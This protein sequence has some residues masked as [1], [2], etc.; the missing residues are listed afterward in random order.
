VALLWR[1]VSARLEI[2]RAARTLLA[3]GDGVLVI[4]RVPSRIPLQRSLFSLKKRPERDPAVIS[5]AAVPILC[6]LRPARFL[7]KKK[8]HFRSPDSDR[9]FDGFRARHESCADDDH[10]R[11]T[12]MTLPE[13]RQ[14]SIRLDLAKFARRCDF[15]SGAVTAECAKLLPR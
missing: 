15:S 2:Y 13:P 6:P 8:C 7:D 14:Q 1:E 10:D 4:D 11:V 3:A 5:M 9:R 12:I